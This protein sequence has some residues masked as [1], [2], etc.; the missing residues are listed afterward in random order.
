M[1]IKNPNQIEHKSFDI[2]EA[3]MKEHNF[4]EQELSIVKRTIH[5]TGDFDYENIV[6]F[7]NNA[8]LEGINAIKPGC[9]IVTDTKMAFSGINKIALQK[10]GCTIDNYIDNEEVRK[11]AQ[12]L[13][14][15][16]SMAAID[17]AASKGVDIFVIGNAPTALFRIGELLE[18]GKISPK[19]IIGVPVGFVGAAES[20]EYART[21]N[22]P[23]I[24]TEGTKGGSNVAAAIV[25]A[26][27]Y[28]A[29]GR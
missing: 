13:G 28:M 5:T 27:L 26:L 23:T 16:R 4:N 3:G 18:E 9:R 15:T 6:I 21:F 1:Y 12:E 19:L 25:N 17:M 8:V 11:I 24:T 22:M 2:I 29:V 20:K 14:I 10:A 7:K